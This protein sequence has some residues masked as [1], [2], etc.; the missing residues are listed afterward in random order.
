M[1]QIKTGQYIRARRKAQGMTQ[2]QLAQRMNVSFQAVSKWENGDAL[3][4]AALLLELADVLNTTTDK[5][6]S[7]GAVI[8]GE[9]RRMRASDVFEGFAHM[10]AVGRCLGE[11]STFFTGMV[12][13]IN[14]KMNID[15]LAYLRDPQARGMMAVEA[16]IQGVMNGYSLDM[17]EVASYIQNPKMLEIIRGYLNTSSGNRL[18]QF[19]E[20][21]RKSRRISEGQIIVVSMQSGSIRLF[22]NDFT[23]ET[24]REIVSELKSPICELLCCS[25]D[26][27]VEAPP[28]LIRSGLLAAFPDNASA[29]VYLMKE[30]KIIG[31]R[32]S[33]LARSE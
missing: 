31:K 30:E 1:D 24:E 29:I 20:G 3:P 11:E 28:E 12:E 9:R 21:F 32:L 14:K 8:A 25:H 7:G 4:D 23:E 13:G 27:K 17:D 26:G 15:L 33:E 2:Q 6:L 10:E 5:L 18:L 16:L 19:A 22:E